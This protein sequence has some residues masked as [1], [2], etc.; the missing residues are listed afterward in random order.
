MGIGQ[1]TMLNNVTVDEMRLAADL[2][3]EIKT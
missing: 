3:E 2:F 1:Y